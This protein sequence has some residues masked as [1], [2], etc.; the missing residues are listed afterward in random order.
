MELN[1]FVQDKLNLCLD[2]AWTVWHMNNDL[3][4]F[5]EWMHERKA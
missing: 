5:V 1:G 3:C 4:T 2:I